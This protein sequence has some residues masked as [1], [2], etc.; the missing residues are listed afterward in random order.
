[1]VAGPF[2]IRGV[3]YLVIDEEEHNFILGNG[4]LAIFGIE[5]SLDD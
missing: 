1:M 5:R 4:V 2:N 3:K